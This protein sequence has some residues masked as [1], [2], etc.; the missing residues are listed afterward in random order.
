[1]KAFSL[2][3]FLRAHI[4]SCPGEKVSGEIHKFSSDFRIRKLL[5]HGLA[6]ILRLI[7]QVGPGDIRDDIDALLCGK[8]TDPLLLLRNIPPVQDDSP[9]RSISLSSKFFTAV[10]MLSAA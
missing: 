3:G 4:R 7:D 8:G 5:N 9:D 1:M 10:E 6:K 2:P